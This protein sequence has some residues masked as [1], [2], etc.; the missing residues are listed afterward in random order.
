VVGIIL[1]EA[2]DAHQ[3]V[4]HTRALIA[5]DRALFGKSQRQIAIRTQLALVDVQVE[6]AVHRL[7]VILLVLDLDRGI[8]VLFIEP[9]MTARLP[10]AGFANMGRV[11]Q[12][13][14]VGDMLVVP[15]ALDLVADH[16][17]IGVPEDQTLTNLVIGAI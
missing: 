17:P 11:D 13:V 14:T 10:Q 1:G 16:A 7:D 12:V 9:Q 4:Q 8:H 3:T 15:V 2:A 5:I 6:G